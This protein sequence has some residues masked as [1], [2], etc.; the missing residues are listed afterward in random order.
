MPF[1]ELRQRTLAIPTANGGA[2]VASGP[3]I[4][5]LAATGEVT[6][7]TRTLANVTALAQAATDLLAIC[8]NGALA[9]AHPTGDFE[10]IGNLGGA[11]PEG[12]A[13]QNGKVYAVVDG[14]KLVAFDLTRASV[15]VLA[16]DPTVTFTGPPMLFENESSVMIADGGFLSLRA[17]SGSETL[18]A[19]IA[20]ASRAFDPAL[21]AL[22]P[23]LAVA[24]AGGA[25]AAARS[26]SDA[27]ILAPD[28]K[29]QRLDNTSCLD[30]F[31]P[32]P[33][34]GGVVFACRSGQ[35]FFVSDK[36]P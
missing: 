21:R 35:L 8:E 4:V 12:G 15:V 10:V 31:R 5:E 19:S 28:G 36:A 16:S 29:A 18:R 33:T 7:Q 3:E 30:P 13:L 27:L 20:E 22:R 6:R 2:L 14:H 9:L 34:Q 17:P 26:D 25:V 23:A 11:A 24:D 32:T 1:A